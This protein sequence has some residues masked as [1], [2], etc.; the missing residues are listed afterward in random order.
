MR[1]TFADISEDKNKQLTIKYAFMIMIF[2]EKPLMQ[3]KHRIHS[4]QRVRTVEADRK[5]TVVWAAEGE[6][7]GISWYPRRNACVIG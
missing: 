7:N 6:G 1:V 3:K 4:L 5:C 2:K